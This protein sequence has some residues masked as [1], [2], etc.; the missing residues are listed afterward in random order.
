MFRLVARLP[1]DLPGPRD[2]RTVAKRLQRHLNL[3]E[4]GL[5]VHHDCGLFS[6]MRETREELDA[7]LADLKARGIHISEGPHHVTEGV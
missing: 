4:D 3:R 7:V 5:R 6:V 2:I 1:D